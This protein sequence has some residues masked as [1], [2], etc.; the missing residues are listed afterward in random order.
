MERGRIFQKN[1]EQICVFSERN[2]SL[3]NCETN[4]RS[5]FHCVNFIE[6]SF[7]EIEPGR[8]R[9]K[10]WNEDKFF[11]NIIMEDEKSL[12]KEIILLHYSLI[13]PRAIILFIHEGIRKFRRLRKI[14]E[15]PSF[16]HPGLI[17]LKINPE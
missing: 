1:D 2:N 17:S 4:Y 11:E 16:N 10:N 15:D 5:K 3:I 13:L 7:S 9:V 14:I 6:I 8:L 12:T